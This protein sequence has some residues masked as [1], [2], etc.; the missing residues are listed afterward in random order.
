MFIQTNDQY[1]V[2]SQRNQKIHVPRSVGEVAIYNQTATLAPRPSY[3][4]KE[5]VEERQQLDAQRGHPAGDVVPPSQPDG[6]SIAAKLN[7]SSAGGYALYLI[8][9][10]AGELVRYDQNQVEIAASNGCP[11]PLVAEIKRRIAAPDASAV[12]AAEREQ[13]KQKMQEYNGKNF[14]DF[15]LARAEFQKGRQ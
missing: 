8:Q 4:T 14:P 9:S 11:R 6:W 7:A 3:G 10:R 1:P 13:A 5:W 12:T 2:V 15:N